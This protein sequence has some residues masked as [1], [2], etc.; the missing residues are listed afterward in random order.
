MPLESATFISQLNSA[1]PVGATDPK[2][3]GDD[4]L[5]LLKLVLQAQFPNLGAAAVTP[6]AAQINA[7][8]G[9]GI[10]GFA[11]PSVTIGLTAVNGSGTAAMRANAAPALSQAIAPTW[12]SL[13]TFA[14]ASGLD[15]S[16]AGQAL[17]TIRDTLAGTNEK[18]WQ[19]R[20]TAGQ[21][22][23]YPLT[24]ANAAASSA[25]RIMR[26]GTAI[27]TV[28]FPNGTLQAGGNLVPDVT[29]S[30]SWSGAHTFTKA[31]TVGVPPILLSSASPLIAFNE[32]DG[33]A[34]NRWWYIFAN[35]EQ[36][37]F[38][39][40]NDAHSVGT[41]WLTV[42]RTGTTIDGI[43]FPNGT[44]QYGGIEVGYRG[45]PSRNLAAS[46][47]TAASDNGRQVRYT[48][49]GHT[50]TLDGDLATNGV[51]MIRN[52]GTGPLTIAASGTLTWFNGGGALSTGSRTLA[53]GGV[54][55]AQHTG[56]GNYEIWGNA[57]LS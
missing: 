29:S 42:D 22:D 41:N 12:T 56:S 20:N 32:T 31:N 11:N 30:P 3:Q 34:N 50:L 16:R 13:H 53:V 36:F 8:V 17:L 14:N 25:L 48:S 52:A 37:Q 57:G 18:G 49:S 43:N 28:N 40:E 6:T 45:L 44:L 51:V 4:H 38:G 54:A 21:F 23:L 1:N 9:S 33:A 35:A 15:V 27:D 2:A 5:R 46:D 26:T 7:V 10:T 39:A 55:S 47:S 19:L 24:D